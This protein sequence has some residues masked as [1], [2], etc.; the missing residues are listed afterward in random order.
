MAGNSS[1]AARMRSGVSTSSKTMWGNGAAA[2]YSLALTSRSARSASM[3]TRLRAVMR[4]IMP[5]GPAGLV[6]GQTV[7]AT[8]YTAAQPRNVPV[9]N[10]RHPRRRDPLMPATT[11][12]PSRAPRV[13]VLVVA[14]NAGGTLART[15]SGSPTPSPRPSTTSWSAT[16]PASTTP[17][18]SVW[19]PRESSLPLTV[20]RHEKN[21]GY[22]GNQKAGYALGD[23]AR[24]RHR[25]AAARRRPVRAGVHR[26][27]VAPLVGGEADAVFG[28]RMIEPRAA[29]RGGM[30]KYKY[31]GNSIL[32]A[33]RTG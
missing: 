33:S 17:T 31:V 11:P 28:S 5:R 18:T 30:P 24:S 1:T 25:G 29:P 16:M 4:R 6:R 12:V 21:L 14:Y 20:V 13:G 15:L 22:G 8:V 26:G 32:T 27:L 23:R 19:P 9:S 7:V 3:S 10:R 2:A